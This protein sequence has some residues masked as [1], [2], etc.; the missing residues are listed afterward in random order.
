MRETRVSRCW[1]GRDTVHMLEARWPQTICETAALTKH[2]TLKRNAARRVSAR[3]PKHFQT[4]FLI[5]PY[6]LLQ[7][8]QRG[9]KT[10]PRV[11][12]GRKVKDIRINLSLKHLLSALYTHGNQAAARDSDGHQVREESWARHPMGRKPGQ[13]EMMPRH[14]AVYS[15]WPGPRFRKSS[16][17][18]VSGTHRKYHDGIN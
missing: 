18:H 12:H 9:G 2:N 8:Q 13:Q 17:L 14:T 6:I 16:L 4:C 1:W 10:P 5:Y 11:R 3:D 15:E 7:R